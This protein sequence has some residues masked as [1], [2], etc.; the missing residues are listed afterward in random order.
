[1]RAYE[2]INPSIVDDPMTRKMLK[3]I[4]DYLRQVN[5]GLARSLAP[6]QTPGATTD[7]DT[8]DDYFYL[9]GRAGGQAAYGGGS[10]STDLLDFYANTDANTARLRLSDSSL[11]FARG[12]N[13]VRINTSDIVYDFTSRTV[14]ESIGIG[15]QLR[16]SSDSQGH[17]FITSATSSANPI[18]NIETPSG[19]TGLMQQW[20]TFS[21]T[22]VGAIKTTGF[23]V[24]SGAVSTSLGAGFIA[25]SANLSFV[26]TAIF[27]PY[28]VGSPDTVRFYD[29][30]LTTVQSYIAND[31]SFNGPVIATSSILS[32]TVTNPALR[33]RDGSGAST[34]M[35]QVQNS[36]GSVTRFTINETASLFSW[37]FSGNVGVQLNAPASD[38]FEIMGASSLDM[39]SLDFGGAG[40]LS[41]SDGSG[42]DTMVM[43]IGTTK[44]S[45][46]YGIIKNGSGLFQRLAI[47]SLGTL[48]TNS[49]SLASLTIPSA[50]WHIENTDDAAVP[51]L[52][53]T[54]HSF[55]SANIA[56][57]TANGEVYID[58][59]GILCI[60][61][62]VATGA[63]GNARVL[64][65]SGVGSLNWLEI[66]DKTTGFSI[67]NQSPAITSNFTYTWPGASGTIV[68]TSPAQTL[69]NK[70]LST[71]GNTL[72]A[73]TASSGVAFVDNTTTSKALRMILSTAS[74][75]TNTAL[76][77]NSTASRTFDYPDASIVLA[78]SAAALTSGRVPFA[79]TGGILTDDADLTFAT[80]T[81]TSTKISTT[82]GT[83]TSAAAPGSPATGDTWNDS[84]QKNLITFPN[85]VKQ[86]LSGVIY[87]TT[88][89]TTVANTVTETTLVGSGV[90]T[91]TLPTNFLVA[92][93]TVRVSAWG[94]YSTTGTPTLRYRVRMGGIAGTVVLDTAAQTTASGVTN[95]GWRVDGLITCRTTGAGGTVFGQGSSTVSSAAFAAASGT[96]D[97]ENTATTAIDTTAAQQV[98]LSAEWGTASASNTI[99]CSNFMVEVLN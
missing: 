60:D 53:L 98:V 19:H 36:D 49:A 93:K 88:A 73:S 50:M 32:S 97:M 83:L 87:T 61:N 48:L 37:Y 76:R 64:V 10:A 63:F 62:S 9:P 6:G 18:L 27:A 23:R 92:G 41:W 86:T 17:V 85:G 15:L 8:L 21:G 55:Q 39:L 58:P 59:F 99:T 94:V 30:T 56:E 45:K 11:S 72:R 38:L 82:L 77:F 70:T 43:G 65:E 91:D 74:A 66:Y 79:T 89:S 20:K 2:G 7:D 28:D 29:P 35:L 90:G 84:T 67:S 16:G 95:R 51:L 25:T 13:T 80:D 31:G 44:T 4:D 33:L 5:Q 69:N 96:W 81:L 71:T 52:K 26:A 54:P 68:L 24:G 46:R 3:T 12:S 40:G 1:M 47:G 57:F 78:G 22:V 14:V 75:S 42:T 34:D